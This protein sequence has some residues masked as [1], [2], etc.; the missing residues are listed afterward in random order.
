[1]QHR[2]YLKRQWGK[3]MEC[4]GV[5]KFCVFSNKVVQKVLIQCA[6]NADKLGTPLHCVDGRWD[7]PCWGRG[8][9]ELV[10]CS[11]SGSCGLLLCKHDIGITKLHRLWV[12][13]HKDHGKSKNNSVRGCSKA[14]VSHR[15]LLHVSICI[16]LES[17]WSEKSSSET[18]CEP[19]ACQV[20]CAD[21]G[22]MSIPLSSQMPP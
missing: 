11:C 16:L 3:G 4:W 9:W 17:Y 20:L 12:W 7:L 13:M 2:L 21:E 18:Q 22:S 1:M 10:I 6:L 19:R 14:L 5:E 15:A 8:V